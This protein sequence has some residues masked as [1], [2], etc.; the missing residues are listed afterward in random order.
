MLSGSTDA[1][2]PMAGAAIVMTEIAFILPILLH[3]HKQDRVALPA[4]E[5][6]PSQREAVVP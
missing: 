4:R 2:G 1:L 3:K 5:H 6:L